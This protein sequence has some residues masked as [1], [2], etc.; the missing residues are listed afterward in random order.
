MFFAISDWHLRY[1][2]FIENTSLPYFHVIISPMYLES[3][4]DINNSILNWNLCLEL[5]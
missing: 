1:F 3:I 2:N 4:A 5:I